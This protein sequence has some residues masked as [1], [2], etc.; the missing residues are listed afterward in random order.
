MNLKRLFKYLVFLMMWL[1]PALFSTDWQGIEHAREQIKIHRM[2]ELNIKVIDADGR[3]LQGASVQVEMQKHAFPFGAAINSLLAF[4]ADGPNPE[5]SH[6]LQIFEENFNSAVL[7]NGMKW[8]VMTNDDGSPDLSNRQKMQQGVEWLEQ[9]D[10]PLRGHNG[11]WP[12][13][14][15]TPDY[16]HDLRLQPD[17]LRRECETRIET[18][19]G[20]FKNELTDWDL[21]NE[22]AEHRDIINILGEDVMIDWYRRA[23]EIDPTT[24]MY[25]NQW[26]VLNGVYHKSFMNWVEYLAASKEAALGG[27]GLQGHATVEQFTEPEQL[28]SVW[29]ILN[30]YREFGLPIKITEFDVEGSKGEDLQ[31]Q[32]L[33]NALTLFFSHPSVAGFTLWGFWDGRHWRNNPKWSFTG[34]NEKAG[35]WREDWTEK[36]AAKTWKRLVFEEWWTAESGITGSNAVFQTRGFLGDYEI[37]VQHG[38]RHKTMPLTLTGSGAEITVQLD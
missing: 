28:A 30:D 10:I 38:D 8:G 19:V 25:V 16:L 27:I 1:T 23:H 35:L 29:D 20:M 22:P 3:P 17:K 32:A 26:A 2:A 13:W 34:E 6:Y 14:R 11:I 9:N 12:S 33:E 21:V 31:A 36:K 37:S 15:N 24:P 5:H 18:I 7:E 4:T